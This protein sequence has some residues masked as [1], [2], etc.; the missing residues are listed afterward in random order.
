MFTVECDASQRAIGAVLSQEG[1]PITLFSEKLNE[2]KQKYSTYDLELHA[3]VQALKK[4]HHYLLPK[5]FVVFTDNHALSFLNGQEKL[6]QRHLK[7]VE[8]LQ[9]YTFTIKHKKGTTNKV[10]DALSRRI[11][12]M[13]EIQLQSVGLSELKDLYKDDKDFAEIYNVCTNFS[14][15]SHASYSEYMI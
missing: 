10:A 15:T 2:A 9:S 4:W 5:E 8:Y 11:M 13:Q 7:W 12:T 1:N 3:M 14:N 6:N